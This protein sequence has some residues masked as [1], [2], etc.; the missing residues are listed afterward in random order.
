MNGPVNILIVED[1]INWCNIYIRIAEREGKGEY[2]TKVA[3]DL[4]CA[5]SAVDEMRFAV[6]FIDIGLN[7]TDD[8]NVD[9]LHVMAKIRATGDNTSIIVITGRSGRD[10]HPITRDAIMRYHSHEIVSKAYI[11]PDNLKALLNS[12]LEAFRQHEKHTRAHEAMRGLR[13]AWEW[14][15]QMILAISY[16]GGIERLRRFLDDLFLE[17]LPIIGKNTDS[18]VTLDEL[19]GIAHASYWSRSVGKPVALCFGEAVHVANELAVA[20][21]SGILLGRYE[22]GAALREAKAYGVSGAV[23][24]LKNASRGMFMETPSSDS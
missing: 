17:Y 6:A 2:I 8:H 10:V 21:S 24:A 13:P 7:L 4:E 9:G 5:Q 14:D 15:A 23:F 20:K 3:P 22:V 16:Q 11:T 18:Q 19:T 12:G 1:D